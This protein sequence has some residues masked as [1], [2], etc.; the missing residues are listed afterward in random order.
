MRRGDRS[1]QADAG[2]Q[3]VLDREPLALV[4]FGEARAR[5]VL[6]DEVRPPVGGD[7]GMEDGHDE[8]VRRE[9]RHEVRLGDELCAGVA[10]ELL[11]EEHLHGDLPSRQTL[12]VEE[13]VG[14][15]A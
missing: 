5:A 8:G 3:C 11:G 6:H 4:A 13:D 14:E 9:L 12:L 15:S 7:V 1:G 2:A 10:P